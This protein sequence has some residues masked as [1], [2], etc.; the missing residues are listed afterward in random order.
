[1]T[2]YH[3]HQLSASGVPLVRQ[4]RPNPLQISVALRVAR[5]VLWVG[6]AK[7]ERAHWLKLSQ[8]YSGL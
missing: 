1:M 7:Y 3:I 2:Q 5:V 8:D 4:P 6:A